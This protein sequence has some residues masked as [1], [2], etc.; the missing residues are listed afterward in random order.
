MTTFCIQSFCLHELV[1]NTLM[2]N[3]PFS[4]S[5]NLHSST[6][7]ELSLG[8]ERHIYASCL[9]FVAN[10][11]ICWTFLGLTILSTIFTVEP[12]LCLL[13]LSFSPMRFPGW[14]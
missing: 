1:P 7:L 13:G 12:F 8:F 5:S 4:E 10:L 2:K 6:S 14:R 9:T 11:I 3:S